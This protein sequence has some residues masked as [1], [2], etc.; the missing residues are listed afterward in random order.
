[1]RAI[2][3]QVQL[4]Q[5]GEALRLPPALSQAAYR[6]IQESL[7][8]ARRHG[9]GGTTVVHLDWDGAG[10]HLRV[11]NRVGAGGHP[12]PGHGVAGITQRAEMFGGTARVGASG[13]VWEVEVHL[14]VPDR[15]AS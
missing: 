9:A 11:V 12:V 13:D 7:T 4:R 8:N 2:G 1:V 5:S 6:I 3:Q 15:V 10:M 14:P